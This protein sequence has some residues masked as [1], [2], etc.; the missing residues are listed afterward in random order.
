MPKHRN[1]NALHPLMRKGGVH[2]QSKTGQRTRDHYK[3]LDEAAECLDKY[4]N[5]DESED[6]VIETFIDSEGDTISIFVC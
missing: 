6:L 4:L 2:T 1:P 5:R 3:L